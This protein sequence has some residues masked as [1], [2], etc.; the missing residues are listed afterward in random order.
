[1]RAAYLRWVVAACA[2][3]ALV[4][5]AA[6]PRPGGPGEAAAREAPAKKRRKP[7]PLKVRSIR[8]KHGKTFVDLAAIGVVRFSDPI[9]LG[10]VTRTTLSFRP[11]RGADVAYTA[12]LEAEGRR[13]VLTPH[14]PLDPGTDYEVVVRPGIATEDGR[15]LR[16]EKRAIFYTDPRFSPYPLLRPD[17]FADLA[18]PMVEGRAFHTASLLRDGRVLL[19]GGAVDA[20][21]FAVSGELFEPASDSF[22]SVRTPI[23]NPRAG[24]VAVDVWQG[25][26][27][28]GGYFMNSSGISA[29][30]PCDFYRPSAN[31][32]DVGPTLLEGR[33]YAAACVLADG[34]ILVTGG[35]AYDATGLARYS[36][37]AEIID[38]NGLSRLAAGRP[39]L[40]R[41]GHTATLLPDGEVL[42][43]GGIA[44]NSNF[45]PTAELFDP[46]T[47][48]FRAT[49]N[50]PANHR[51]LH[52]ATWIADAG[53]A[54][55]ADG[56]N[57]VVEVY[58]PASERFFTGG[59]SSFF[60]RTLA[61]AAAFGG[62][63]ILYSGGLEQRG[64]QTLILSS[65]DLFIRSAGDQGRMFR[66]GAVLSE[67]RA[68]HTATTLLDGGVLI[69][70][71]LAEDAAF[72]NLE[73][74]VRFTPDEE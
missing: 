1:M 47:E 13:L 63:K 52:T 34:R 57:P 20:L 26:L 64:D 17:Q 11:L 40:R 3:A 4:L 25:V 45:A 58:D 10:T 73:T 27:V 38:E 74:A 19:A 51:Q 32:F 66:V 21:N 15:T 53:V 30:Q 60:N 67:P 68:A 71:G 33:D 28:I 9:D 24:H 7:A 12:S 22:R 69:A 50:A 39:V 31:S 2:A 23:R 56:G 29:V 61:A 44:S 43:V 35:L 6:S 41:A 72:P 18:A 62:D 42:I 8:P 5:P 16:T 48:T 55:L 65:M 14:V 46:V 54:V 37:T 49:K 59:G 70:G 36:T